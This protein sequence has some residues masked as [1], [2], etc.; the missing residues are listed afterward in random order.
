[1]QENE[2]KV[3]E[4]TRP[5]HPLLRIEVEQRLQREQICALREEFRELRSELKPIFTYVSNSR[6]L[7]KAASYGLGILASLGGIYALF[8]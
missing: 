5:E 6:F 3:G 8:S 4:S 7:M 1:M 2:N